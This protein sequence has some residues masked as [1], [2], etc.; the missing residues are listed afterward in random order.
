MRARM[1]IEK[2]VST[3]TLTIYWIE[4]H[5][6][7]RQA[8]VRCVLCMF[9]S[10]R[11]SCCCF[12][13]LRCLSLT[14]CIY[15]IQARF[16]SVFFFIV[17]IFRLFDDLLYCFLDFDE[18]NNSDWFQE[19]CSFLSKK[20]PQ[21]L[22]SFFILFIEI[23]RCIW[24]KRSNSPHLLHRLLFYVFYKYFFSEWNF[25]VLSFRSINYYSS[26]AMLN[27]LRVK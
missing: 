19:F 24:I 1:L 18:L 26:N 12:G 16:V 8:S 5:W 3:N 23:I 14:V 11:F 22:W 6:L 9:A 21:R 17:A 25:S 7:K 2:F 4:F 27:Q 13:S 20:I 15:G 10:L